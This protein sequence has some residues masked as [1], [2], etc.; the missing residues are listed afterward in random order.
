M[1]RLFAQGAFFT[2]LVQVCIVRLTGRGRKMPCAIINGD[3]LE[4]VLGI[5]KLCREDCCGN[6]E[7]LRLGDSDR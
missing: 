4:T 3:A 5:A 6:V 7:A 2:M 1:D